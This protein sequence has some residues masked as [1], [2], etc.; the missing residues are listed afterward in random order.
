VRAVLPR[1]LPLALVVGLALLSGC[2]HRR[3]GAP[4]P[5]RPRWIV[6]AAAGPAV[7][8]RGG[9]VLRGALRADNG[10]V[11]AAPYP[12]SALAATAQ[13]ADGTWRFASVDGTVYR[14]DDFSGPLAVVAAL[15]FRLDP[16]ALRRAEHTRGVHSRG[17]LLVVDAARGAHLVAPD[18][19]HRPLGLGRVLAACFSSADDAWA[20]SE[21]GVLRAS[22]DGGRSFAVVRAPAGVPLAVFNADADTFLRTTAGSF[23][24]AG[25][26]FVPD[27]AAPAPARWLAVPRAVDEGLADAAAGVPVRLDPT[28]AAALPGGRVAQLRGAGLELVDART[29]RVLGR[30]A[31]PGDGCALRAAHGGLRAVCRHDAWATLVAARDAD[32]PG[33][34]VLRDEARAE[35]AGEPTFDDASPAWI[36]AAPCAQHPARDPRDLCA[37]DARGAARDLRLPAPAAVVAM[38]RGAALAVDASAPPRAYLLRDGAA[39]PFALPPDLRAPVAA[40]W[41]DAGLTLAHA[42]PGAPV[43]LSFAADPAADPPAWR[44]VALGPG[45]TR[46]V[47][48]A[49]GAALLY[50]DD[51]RSLAR[52]LAG[53]P[54]VALPSPVLGAGA[55][56]AL[57]PDAPAFCV[58]PWC[59][60]GGALTLAPPPSRPA[61]ALARGDAPPAPAAPRSAQRGVR[62]EHGTVTAAPEIDRG[63]AV[64]G[65][66]VR[67][68]LA[69]AT[70]S[71]AW[72]GETARGSVTRAVALRP[73]APAVVRGVQG[74]TAPAALVELCAPAGCDH[75]LALASGFHD[76]GLG[77]A[78]AG[79]VDVLL[80]D[81][82]YLARADDARDGVSLVT[83]VALD[84]AGAVT[85]RRTYALAAD[86]D[87]AHVG[88]WAGRDGLWVDDGAGAMRFLALGADDAAVSVPAPGAAT[89][90][91]GADVGATPGEARLVQRVA[92]VRGP[93]WFVELGEWQVEE[94]LAVGAAGPCVRSIT[95]GEARDE[96]EASAGREEREPV[97]SFVLRAADGDAFAGR[98]WSGER[99]VALRCRQE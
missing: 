26:S 74:S 69:G 43:A 50:G 19:A 13:L 85:A 64:S 49:D 62:C 86:P 29:G 1:P 24:L 72:S 15:P 89:R 60:L 4:R 63:A 28:A 10:R 7:R 32:R 11:A 22:R 16:V 53:S 31:L 42:T 37:Y 68:S 65:H 52:S 30:D 8:V 71:V 47:F 70:L 20:V 39:V 92:Q 76:L 48:A 80:R 56:L 21:P 36:V 55:A 41:T 88:R 45:F 97:R 27:A 75:L 3:A 34:T 59:R 61:L 18:G 40:S 87:D 2:R 83:L 99:A 5:D 38:H 84:A 12:A 17:A 93:G 77:R 91:C 58:G 82:G 81:G 79:G 35:P 96:R 46:A 51:A 78:T 66:A 90:A 67:V 14:A 44:R 33:W 57:D 9:L 94:V 73:G 54:A 6:A 25:G 98:A 95:G 23:R